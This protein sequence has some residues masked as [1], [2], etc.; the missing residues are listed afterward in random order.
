MTLDHTHDP[1]ARSWLAAAN[2]AGG[3]FPIQNL[4][5]AVLRR[6]GSGEPFRGAVAIGDQALDLAALAN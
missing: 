3:D 5:F 1:T 4:P 2:A 6:A